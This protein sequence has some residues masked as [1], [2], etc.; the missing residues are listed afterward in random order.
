MATQSIQLLAP[1]TYTNQVIDLPLQ[2]QNKNSNVKTV[3]VRWVSPDGFT[4][5]ATTCEVNFQ[6]DPNR[7][8]PAGGWDVPVTTS[9]TGFFFGGVFVGGGIDKNTGQPRTS[10]QI[11]TDLN[12]TFEQGTLTYHATIAI[13]GTVSNFALYL[14]VIS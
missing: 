6:R 4:D 12:P 1:G 5:P 3:R 11:Q 2:N 9:S 8:G 7:N 14:D 10:G 13:T